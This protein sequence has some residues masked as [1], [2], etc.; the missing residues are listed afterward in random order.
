MSDVNFVNEPNS[1]WGGPWTEKKLEAFEKYVKAYLS[2]MNNFPYW[3]TIYFDGFAGSGDRGKQNDEL[4]F[5]LSITDDETK[6][7]QGAAERVIQIKHPK[8]FDY[9]YFIE[10]DA[11]SSNKLKERLSQVSISENT[12]LVFRSEDCNGEIDKLAGALNDKSNKLAALIF[13]D[14][15]GMHINWE[16]IAKLKGSRSDVWILIPTGVIVNRLLDRKGKLKS[17]K[18]L[19]SFLGM[20]EEE[21]R[22]AFYRTHTHPSLFGEEIEVVE[23]VLDPINHIAR[24]YIDNLKGIW[25]HVTETPL[26]LNNSKGRPIFHFVCASNNKNA[27]KIAQQIIE[28]I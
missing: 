12:Q 1:S 25:E 19:T 23:K 17:M 16:S 13:L 11:E 10:K 5:Q 22:N 20:N 27:V 9:C 8:A 4:M 15:F 28:K 26:R 18:T 6:I 14:P 3:K 2:I 24:I 21:I 7:Y